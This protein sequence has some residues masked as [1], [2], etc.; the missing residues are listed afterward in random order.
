MRNR[1]EEVARVGWGGVG[2]GMRKELERK[3]GGETDW[4]VKTKTKQKEP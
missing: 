2:K 3:E 4:N 1:G